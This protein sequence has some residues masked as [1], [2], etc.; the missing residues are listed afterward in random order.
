ML[1]LFI[2]VLALSI[3]PLV[4]LVIWITFLCS[5]QAGEPRFL[6]FF[7]L[8]FLFV[9]LRAL[10][11]GYMLVWR[12]PWLLATLFVVFAWGGSGEP[13]W[14]SRLAPTTEGVVEGVTHSVRLLLVMFSVGVF[15]EMTPKTELL[16]AIRALLAPLRAMGFDVDRSVVRVMLV[17][18]FVELLPR[19]KDWRKL[20]EAPVT[21]KVTHVEIVVSSLSFVDYLILMTLIGAVLLAIV[22][23]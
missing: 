5:V 19:P 15:L 17:L 4:R 2:L 8:P 13:L 23:L 3:H 11:R 20:L 10:K 21:T 14:D 18:K 1:R 7:G 9:G 12:A 22:Y 6:V 16:V